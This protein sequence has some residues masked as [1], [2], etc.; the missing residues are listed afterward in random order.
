MVT[1]GDSTRRIP[2]VDL[3]SN[4]MPTLSRPIHPTPFRR[5]SLES[6]DS[7][8]FSEIDQRMSRL[9]GQ[10]F[11]LMPLLNITLI[12]IRR[13]GRKVKECL[14]LSL[15]TEWI[16]LVP[17]SRKQSRGATLRSRTTERSSAED[18]LALAQLLIVAPT[19]LVDRIPEVLG[20]YSLMKTQI[21]PIE[22]DCLTIHPIRPTVKEDL[23]CHAANLLPKF[24]ARPEIRPPRDAVSREVDYVMKKKRGVV[25]FWKTL[26]I[27]SVR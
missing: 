16:P 7:V 3:T 5:P 10:F 17:L 13:F 25:I 9:G 1:S 21:F 24:L 11:T 12:G 2:V 26:M 4:D 14:P 20:I 8:D 6:T 23:V 18:V 15:T 19:L 22:V 27:Q